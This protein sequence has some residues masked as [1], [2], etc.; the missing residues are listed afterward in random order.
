MGEKQGLIKTDTPQSRGL[1]LSGLPP[2]LHLDGGVVSKQR[3]S[4]P[5]QFTDMAGQGLQQRRGTA[6]GAPLVQG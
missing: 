4:G 6:P 1:G 3:R 2:G 5:H